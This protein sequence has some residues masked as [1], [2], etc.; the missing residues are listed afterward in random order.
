MKKLFI[1]IVLMTLYPQSRTFAANELGRLFMTESQR[2]A[3]QRL[4]MQKPPEIKPV[5]VKEPKPEIVEPVKPDVGKI[6]VNGLVYRKN[7]K[8]TAWIN[9]ANSFDGNAGNDLVEIDARDIKPDDVEIVI[10]V[11][12][13]KV[14][15]K[16]GDTYDPVDNSVDSLKYRK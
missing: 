7:G 1:F 9:D 12:D 14:N 3:L 8:S 11:T 6:S 15:L 2:E 10:P 5:V 13:T 16:A 4:R